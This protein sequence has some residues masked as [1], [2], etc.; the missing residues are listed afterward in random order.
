VRVAVIGAGASGLATARCLID[1]GLD[2]VV[3]DRSGHI[4]GLWNYDA[5]A[6]DGGGPAYRSLHTNTSRQV[7]AFSDFPMPAHL[8][9]FPSRADVLAYLNAYSAHFGLGDRLRLGVEVRSLTD[10]EGR[11]VLTFARG[12]VVEQEMFDAV[13]VCTGLYHQ[14]AIPSIDGIERFA[15]QVSHSR[16]YNRPEP[17]AGQDVVVVGVGSSGAEIAAELSDVARTVTLSTSR[18]AWFVPHYIGGRPYDHQLTRAAELLPQ[19]LRL[20]IFRALLWREYRRL[21]AGGSS[22]G[23]LPL[24]P[25]DLERSRF[26]PNTAIVPRLASGAIAVR[27]EIRQIDERRVIFA[28]GT[29]TSPDAI[30]FCT[31]Y[32]LTFPFLEEPLR[33]S[34]DD[35]ASLFEYVFPR[36]TANLAF[37]GLCVVVGPYPPVVELQARWVARVFAG[38]ADLPREEEMSRAIDARRARATRLGVPPTR[39]QLLDSMDRLAALIDARPRL[40]RHPG[41]LPWLLGGPPAAAQF[42]LDGPGRWIGAP[43]AIRSAVRHG[44]AGGVQS[45]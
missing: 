6:E 25:F 43:R 30:I 45:T 12:G 5:E 10:D 37:I 17:Y 35:G 3:F 4:G 42:R 24:P 7:M 16:S 41:L 20:R 15:G 44:G 23:D 40:L 36:G 11:W 32:R 26:T 34:L 19:A 33:S 22:I 39:V 8:P 29:D 21:G 9:D 2:P 18:G 13:V 27:P 1:E 31:G 28:D 14:P 38:S